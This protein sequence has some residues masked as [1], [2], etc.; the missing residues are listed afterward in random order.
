VRREYRPQEPPFHVS[1]ELVQGCT[2]ACSFCGMA[3]IQERPGRDF[4]FMARST[5]VK[6]LIQIRD[7]GW[8]CRIGFAMRGE[9]SMH[10]DLYNMIQATRGWL[11]KANI[12]MLSNGSGFLKKPGPVVNVP[13][14][15]DAGLSTLGLDHYEHA[16]F[17]PKIIDALAERAP[18]RSGERHELGFKF[19]KY[20]DDRAGNPHQ[21][22]WNSRTLIQVQDITTATAGTH[23]NL[24]NHAGLGAAPDYSMSGKRC[25]HPFR[26]M[27]VHWDG[28]VPLCCNTWDSPFYVGNVLDTP[29]GDLWQSDAM[30]AAREKLM[31]GER[32]FA[33]C[34]GCNHRSYRVGLLPD[35]KGQGR[36]HPPDE[37]TA[38]DI[39][40]ALSRGRHTPVVRI[41]WKDKSHV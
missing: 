16:N 36:V 41:P 34:H 26:R 11:P 12:L 6:V 1:I 33:P 22:K 9:P 17:V 27:V 7:L 24:S 18:L 30:G 13:R 31:R 19:H 32:D 25:H 29:L 35:L 23:S 20:P 4:H 40:K 10:P 8:K 28:N 3:A 15:F 38:A 14:A 21:Q 37:Q 5:L 2:L 39:E